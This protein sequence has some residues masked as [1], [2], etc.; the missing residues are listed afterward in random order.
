[1]KNDIEIAI[2]VLTSKIVADITSNDALKV[3]QAALNLANTAA[4]L[5]H[6]KSKDDKNSSLDRS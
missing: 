6:L 3:T 1:M 2:E 4:T 5:S